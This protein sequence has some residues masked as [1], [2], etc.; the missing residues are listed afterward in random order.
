MN[1][2]KCGGQ[3]EKLTKDMS[4]Q[5]FEEN[6]TIKNIDYIKCNQCGKEKFEKEENTK[7]ITRLLR[8][9]YLD[10]RTVVD[11]KEVYQKQEK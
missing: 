2:C 4:Y 10:K 1:K 7:E 3:Y 8:E 6:I 9:A 5:M 11:F